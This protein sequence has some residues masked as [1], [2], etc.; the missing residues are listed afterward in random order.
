VT[1]GTLSAAAGEPGAAVVRRRLRS[2]LGVRLLAGLAWILHRLP[3]RALH[4]AAHAL[5]GA[6]HM[7]QPRRRRL[8]RENL[9][10]V[11]R[12]LAAEG[13]A[14]P[15]SAA[16][17]ADR[18]ALD[19]LVR[20]AFGH[21]AR[22]Y[23]ESLI[24]ERYA[25][26]RLAE[27]LA[28]DDPVLVE[29]LFGR[30]GDAARPSLLL[31]GMH[32]GAIEIPALWASQHGVRLTSPMETIPDPD[33]QA[34]LLRRRAASGVTLIPL[35]GAH[36]VLAEGLA[37]GESIAIVADRLVAGSGARVELFGAPARLPIGPAVLALESGRPAWAVGVRRTGPGE[38]RARL[39]PIDL[40]A[41][42]SRRD[43]L[44]GFMANQARAFER[45]VADA[46]EQWWT[47]FFPI[48]SHGGKR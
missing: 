14:N 9:E 39:E 29:R 13:L 23:L 33:L 8:V 24:L 43:R 6:L 30:P 18:G 34:F 12:W 40:P 2:R 11:C 27:R 36:R 16:A 48:W 28:P 3:D 17:A 7:T 35:A 5:G 21:Y 10:R 1:A 25:G 32:F 19:R 37:A 41:E 38:Y 4:R 45:L 22:T 20:D 47:L 26:G 31:V 44:A 15:A 46:P 42:G